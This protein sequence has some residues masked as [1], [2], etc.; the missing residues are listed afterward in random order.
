[1]RR[2]PVERHACANQGQGICSTRARLRAHG[3]GGTRYIYTSPR[4]VQL[5]G[6]SDFQVNHGSVAHADAMA[7]CRIGPTNKVTF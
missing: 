2:A 3:L 5:P 7:R 1:M 6:G 4:P